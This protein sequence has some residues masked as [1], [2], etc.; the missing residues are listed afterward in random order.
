MIDRGAR[1][2]SMAPRMANFFSRSPGFNRLLRSALRLAPERELP[3][4]AP[5]SFRQWARKHGVPNCGEETGHAANSSRHIGREVVLWL[6]P[7]NNYLNTETSRADLEVLRR[8][9]VTVRIPRSHLCCG[10]PLYDFG[11][12]DRAKSYLRQIMQVLG[13]Q[14][15]A[16]L[17]IVVLE[18]SCASVFRDE[19]QNLFPGE[20]RAVRLGRQTFLLSEFLER[21]TPGYHPPPISGKVLL[22]GHCH[23]KPLMP[24]NHEDSLL[25]KTGRELKSLDSGCGGR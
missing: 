4:F 14:I 25:R 21:Q 6:D 5:S 16:G 15:D 19:L 17:P 20:E 10:R 8:A 11:M 9:G 13:E 1:L 23:H 7:F 22:H 2:E 3:R 24:I 12:I 18:P